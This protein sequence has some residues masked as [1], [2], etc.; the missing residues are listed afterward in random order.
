M[1]SGALAAA[2]PPLLASMTDEQLLSS[3]D[4]VMAMIREWRD[5]PVSNV[6][7]EI[8]AKAEE[9]HKEV[10]GENGEAEQ[11]TESSDEPTTA[12]ESTATA[13]E[14]TA[15]TTDERSTAGEGTA[16]ETESGGTSS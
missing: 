10:D 8:E 12:D 14:G 3:L 7:S 16:T 11:S 9:Y 15:A 2:G 5:G 13:G 4:S 6:N 1:M